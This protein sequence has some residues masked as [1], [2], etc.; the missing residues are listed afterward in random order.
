MLI[1]CRW[2][3]F[4]QDETATADALIRTFG[5]SAGD[6][7]L[8]YS[9]QWLASTNDWSET[10]LLNGVLEVKNLISWPAT[11]LSDTTRPIK[12]ATAACASG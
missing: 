11:L 10:Y 4:L 6:L 2:G 12:D 8:N 1:A 7:V 5:S 9:A 3:V